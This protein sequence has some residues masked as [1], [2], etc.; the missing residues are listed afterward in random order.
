MIT[1]DD[2]QEISRAQIRSFDSFKKIII[3]FSGVEKLKSKFKRN[4]VMNDLNNK[5]LDKSYQDV[6]DSLSQIRKMKYN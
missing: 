1:Q 6:E 4:E 2:Y 3:G 5:L